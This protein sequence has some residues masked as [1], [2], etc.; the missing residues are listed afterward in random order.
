VTSRKALLSWSSGKDSAFALHEVLRSEL[1]EVV[2]LLTT[3]T[4]EFSRVSMH[5]VREELLDRQAGSVGLPLLKVVLPHPC[6]NEQYE[7]AMRPVLERARSEGV[8]AVV[9][10]DLFLDDIR[11]YRE[12]RMMAVGIECVF[13]LWHRDTR[14]LAQEMIGAGLRARIC[15]LDPR[16]LDRSF[17]GREF[18]SELLSALPPAVDPCGEHGE[19]HTF[20][21]ESPEFH[22]PVTVKVGETVER[23]G[24][25]F[26]DLVPSEAAP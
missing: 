7:Q 9:F 14:E 12:S 20:V 2:G 19:F 21:T 8:Q 18:D 16:K 24:F 4:G 3:V 25:V 5:G 17:A 6:S 26:T 10:G 22:V 23:E 1:C 13:P 15:C 11:N